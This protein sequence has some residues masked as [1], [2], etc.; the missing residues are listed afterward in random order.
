MLPPGD[1]QIRPMRIM[2]ELACPRGEHPV[3]HAN[4]TST[5]TVRTETLERAYPTIV[6]D[7][8]VSQ[9]CLTALSTRAPSQDGRTTSSGPWPLAAVTWRSTPAELNEIGNDELARH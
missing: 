3:R 8:C 7:L 6:T 9:P 4:D 1:A 2:D 5:S